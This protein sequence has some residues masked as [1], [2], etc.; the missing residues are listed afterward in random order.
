MEKR[1]SLLKW[2]AVPVIISLVL[3]FSL[4]AF[5]SKD[6]SD[7][8]IKHR[9]DMVVIDTLKS[10]GPLE[11]SAV[12]FLHDLHTEAL[13]KDNQS[14]EACHLPGKSETD[15]FSLKFKR[16]TDIAGK[17]TMDIY[18]EECSGCHKKMAAADKKAGPV[19]SCNDCHREQTGVISTRVPMAFDKSLHFRH[20]EAN[21][22]QGTNKGDCAICHHEYDPAAKKLVYAK[23]REGSCR[24]CHKKTTQENRISM[25]LA[26]H[27]DCTDCH[28]RKIAVK[29]DAGP[30]M[31]EGCHDPEARQKIEKLDN[32]PRME[33]KQ[34]DIVLVRL[35]QPDGKKIEAGRMNPVPFNHK[36]HEAA[37][38]TCLVC[39]HENLQ[40]CSQCH[41]PTGAKEGNFVNLETA[42]HQAGSDQSC[43]GCHESNQRKPQCAA[44]HGSVS[45]KRTPAAAT[46][47]ACHVAPETKRLTVAALDD[48]QLA[49]RLY[50]SRKRRK[51]VYSDAE[52]P[53][54]VT[55]GV[56]SE[57]YE[58]VEL[59]HRK[60]ARTLQNNIRDDEMANFYHREKGAVCQGCHH[61]SPASMK[62]PLCASCHG[63]PFDRRNASRPGLKGAYHQQC[64]GCH[65]I[66]KLAKPVAVACTDCHKEKQGRKTTG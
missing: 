1:K 15:R 39:H 40:S 19:E 9:A 59:P 38:S 32:V 28:R 50:Q 5:S 20:M 43:I 22:D 54:K 7:E 4:E 62:P 63:Q 47:Q 49:E 35:N 27:T 18:H 52:I 57:R 13:A 8:N 58:P 45:Q 11:R 60:M 2:A 46:C 31:C 44:C 64:M 17:A 55:I 33:R 21:K 26:S 34:P 23:D 12:V 36:A 10:F 30:V 56:L 37:N 41:T 24:Y 66:L 6:S 14:C 61:N 29:T 65:R 42:M 3:V 53:E 16:L 48:Q 51:I 25:R